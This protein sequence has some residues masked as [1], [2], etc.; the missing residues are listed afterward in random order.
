MNKT[1]KAI[2]NAINTQNIQP[3]EL[4]QA[5]EA[6]SLSKGDSLSVSRVP[7]QKYTIRFGNVSNV[8]KVQV[9]VPCQDIRNQGLQ[10]ALITALIERD[11]PNIDPWAY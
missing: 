2:I 10:A 5:M 11:Q 9:L 4:M 7:H 3:A 6:E 1:H 8:Q